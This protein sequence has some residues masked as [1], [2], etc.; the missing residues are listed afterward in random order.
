MF[1]CNKSFLLSL[2][3]SFMLL[4]DNNT[5]MAKDIQ[6]LQKNK[7]EKS[8][9]DFHSFKTL[10]LS[11]RSRSNCTNGSTDKYF[12]AR[13]SFTST[14]WTPTSVGSAKKLEKMENFG[15]FW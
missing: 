14:V 10:P 3:F 6:P 4:P 13:F 9:L 2:L 7:I 1:K 12:L 11:P 8:W 5:L 15:H